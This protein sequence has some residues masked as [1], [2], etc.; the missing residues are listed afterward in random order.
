[1]SVM[2]PLPISLWKQVLS[3][4]QQMS[5]NAAVAISVHRNSVWC[6]A[7]VVR[8]LFDCVCD[9]IRLVCL[10]VDCPDWLNTTRSV[11]CCQFVWYT[12]AKQATSNHNHTFKSKRAIQNI[13]YLR[14]GV[15]IEFQFGDNYFLSIM[16]W[17]ECCVWITRDLWYQWRNI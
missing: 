1:M 11:T 5:H 10:W 14:F 12:Y 13:S 3:A 15:K 8:L 7:K 6:P 2:E 16:N 17:L 9:T 4:A